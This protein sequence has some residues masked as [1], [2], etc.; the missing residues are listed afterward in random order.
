MIVDPVKLTIL[1]IITK[2]NTMKTTK[3]TEKKILTKVRKFK[4]P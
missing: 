4:V 3:F 1:I 2:S